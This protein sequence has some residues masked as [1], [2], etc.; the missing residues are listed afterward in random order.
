MAPNVRLIDLSMEVHQGMM[1]YPNVAKPVIVEMESHAAM[2]RS[3][4]TDQ[5]GVDEITNHCLIVTG[6]HIGTH[7]DSWGHVKPDAPRAEGIPIEYCYGNGV[8]LDLTHKGAGDEITPGD[9]DQA[10]RSL[11]GYRIQPRDIVLLRTDAA[12]RRFD[13]SYLTDHPGMTKE[14]VHGLLDRGV[15]VMGI[16]AIGFDPPVTKMF[17]RRKFWEAHRVMREREYYHLENLCNLHEI[18]PPYHSFTV[19]VLPVKWR[20]ASAAPVRAVAI[21]AAP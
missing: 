18:P 3:I 11:G 21:V 4:G 19:S 17:E 13:K 1:T 10:E 9:I 15:M 7:I 8:V 5:Y 2:A 16:D 12:K 14:A 6:D 20:G